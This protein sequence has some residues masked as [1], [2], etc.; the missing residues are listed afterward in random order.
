MFK[1]A[2]NQD[3]DDA[4][5]ASIRKLSPSESIKFFGTQSK[6][7]VPVE[8]LKRLYYSPLTSTV[9][10]EDDAKI[11][12][13]GN[14]YLPGSEIKK[15][16]PPAWVEALVK[17][18]QYNISNS[19]YENL[20]HSEG[21]AA[22]MGI[23]TYDPST[24]AKGV[25]YGGFAS[26]HVGEGYKCKT[27]GNK[28][29]SGGK[30]KS[31]GDTQPVHAQ[32]SFFWRGIK[33]EAES[34]QPSINVDSLQSLTKQNPAAMN[35][36][37]TMYQKYLKE[38][39]K[40]PVSGM[41]D[42]SQSGISGMPTLSQIGLAFPGGSGGG[43][44]TLPSGISL[45]QKQEY[46]PDESGDTYVDSRGH[47]MGKDHNGEVTDYGMLNPVNPLAIGGTG[48]ISFHTV[49]VGDNPN[50][51]GSSSISSNIRPHEGMMGA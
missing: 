28:A 30:C 51:V 23:T 49:N 29:V 38:T 2:S 19:R 45:G 26:Q 9:Q 3:S 5:I 27:C 37:Y 36:L 20:A 50:L 15:I 11:W 21:E 13:S 10:L 32:G 12:F 16:L 18:G 43:G 39:G 22:K 8:Y 33:K 1:F 4:F 7:E 17:G 34:V 31:C 35:M 47:I 24:F 14:S 44:G 41:P 25:G 46:T 40:L 6:T 42:A 48:K